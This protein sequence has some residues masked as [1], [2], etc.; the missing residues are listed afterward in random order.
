MERSKARFLAAA[1]AIPGWGLPAQAQPP[2]APEVVTA[3]KGAQDPRKDPLTPKPISFFELA[4]D[5]LK[6]SSGVDHVPAKVPWPINA[7]PVDLDD[8]GDMDIVGGSVA[9]RKMLWF[10]NRSRGGKFDFV[11][12]AIALTPAEA[13]AP[14]LT[15]HGFNMSFVDM[16][17]DGR[18]DIVTFDTPPLVGKRLLWLEQPARAEEP[19]R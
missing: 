13:G 14:E 3:N 10:E 19:W 2:R 4:G 5:P 11:E 17:R 9:E 8:D 7:E 18:L 16:N 1:A 15:V 6:D 12:H